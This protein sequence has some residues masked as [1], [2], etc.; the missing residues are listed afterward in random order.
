MKLQR[1]VALKICKLLD[2]HKITYY[3]LS[4]RMLTDASTI[5]HILHEEVKTIRLE[6]LHKITRA[7]NITI[8]DFFNDDLFKNIDD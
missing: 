8:Q 7:F 4:K 2:E 5:K 6:T 1:A 3:E